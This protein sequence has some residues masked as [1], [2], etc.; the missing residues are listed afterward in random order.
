MW[1]VYPYMELEKGKLNQVR[2]RHWEY[3]WIIAEYTSKTEAQT[4]TGYRWHRGKAEHSWHEPTM[5]NWKTVVGAHW[6]RVEDKGLQVRPVTEPT[7][8]EVARLRGEI[9][10]LEEE[11][12]SVRRE[13]RELCS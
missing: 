8:A 9:A 10:K 11:Q 12:K 13:L 3:G 5:H 6:F 4:V 7:L 1:Q 2:H